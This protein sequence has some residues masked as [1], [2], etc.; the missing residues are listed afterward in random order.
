MKMRIFLQLDQKLAQT[1]SLNVRNSVQN[2]AKLTSSLAKK[3]KAKISKAIE[4]AK[5]IYKV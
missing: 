3:K 4:Q 5:L 1:E 2:D